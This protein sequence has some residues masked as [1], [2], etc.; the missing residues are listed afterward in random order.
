MLS[1]REQW[2]G[3]LFLALRAVDFPAQVLAAWD[4]SLRGKPFAVVDQDPE[5]HKT[6]VLACS[7]AARALGIEAGLPFAAVRRRWR[8]VPALY[9]NA[10]WEDSLREELKALCLRI[11]PEFEVK[12]D[13]SALL[14]LTGTPA[15]RAAE[16]DTLARKLRQAVCYRTGLT[17]VALGLAATRL[18]ARVMAR[19]AHPAGFLA[20]PPGREAETLAPLEPGALPGLSPQ[21]RQRIRRYALASVGQIRA[22]GR[23]A[24]LAGFGSEGDKLYA[25]AS[26]MDPAPAPVRRPEI[27]AEA[28][29]GEDAND[30]D[31]LARQVR[32]TADLLVYRLRREGAVAARLRVMIRYSDHKTARRTLAVEPP[33]DGFRELSELALRAFRAL[34][35]RRVALRAISLSV[36]RPEA[37]TGQVDLF[38]AAADRKQRAIAEALTRIRARS[39]FEAIAAAGREAS[40]S[41]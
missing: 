13:G 22:L 25:L 15:L 41:G 20:C 5:S 24:L 37:E 39:G 31:F 7:P 34:H 12:E 10:A 29:L 36:A 30:D 14:D 8:R 2:G 32:A 16:P 21:C 18:M 28:V 6:A 3:P 17:D 1:E 40:V 38:E 27:A 23:Q 11:T 26:G 35:L 9:R 19:Q 4:P 33:T